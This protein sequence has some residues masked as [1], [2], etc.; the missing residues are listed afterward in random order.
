MDTL[1]A[2]GDSASFNGLGGKSKVTEAGL[3][4]QDEE[5]SRETRISRESQGMD[6]I[7]DFLP[8]LVG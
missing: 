7:C 6:L 3:E 5:R 2:V 4:G 8:Y 1:A